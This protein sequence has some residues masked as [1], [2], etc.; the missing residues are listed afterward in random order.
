VA[1]S[2][3]CENG[4]AGLG[5]ALINFGGSSLTIN[6]CTL[7][8]NQAV[9]GAGGAGANGGNG[10][11]GGVY[12]DGQSSLTIT[13]ST[14]TGNSATGGAAGSGGSAG[15][16]IGG[17]AYFAGGGMVCLDAF[18]QAHAKNNHAST[19]GDDLFGDFTTC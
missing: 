7:S 9:G 11:G 12:N 18:T 19:I 13:G 16:G 8:G 15:Q 6:G 1:A 14:I 17:G 2:L 3:S 4:G 10:F 5:G